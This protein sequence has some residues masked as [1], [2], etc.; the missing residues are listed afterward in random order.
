MHILIAL[1]IS[2]SY[3]MAGERIEVVSANQNVVEVARSAKDPRFIDLVLDSVDSK[4]KVVDHDVCG[5]ADFSCAD[6]TV[7]EKIPVVKIIVS[8]EKNYLHPNEDGRTEYV[9]FTFPLSEIPKDDLKVLK[10]NSG[11]FDLNGKKIKARKKLAQ[12][13]FSLSFEIVVR[14]IE[15]VDEK[16]SQ[17][18][19]EEELWCDDVIHYRPAQIRVVNMRIS[20]K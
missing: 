5:D 14:D 4:V 1:F 3:A 8:Y 19:S 6:R 2:F 13:L 16:K 12:K 10:A 9:E 11:L 20:K 15:V 18:C 17:Y 7:I